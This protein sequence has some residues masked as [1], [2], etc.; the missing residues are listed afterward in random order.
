MQKMSSDDKGMSPGLQ[1]SSAG[2]SHTQPG[3]VVITRVRPA[4]RKQSSMENELL[5]SNTAFFSTNFWQHASCFFAVRRLIR[6]C[7]CMHFD[8][9]DSANWFNRTALRKAITAGSSHM[10]DPNTT[11]AETV[12][13]ILTLFW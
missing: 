10:A 8:F 7:D 1:K 2:F 11:R 13:G 12:M 9:E 4:V 3:P 6:T 5:V